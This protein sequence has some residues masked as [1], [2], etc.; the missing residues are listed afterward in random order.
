[1]PN[2]ASVIIS[3]YNKPHELEM[4]LCGLSL[5]NKA[6]S[7]ILVADDGSTQKT[8]TVIEKWQQIITSP[9]RHIWHEDIGNRKLKICNTAVKKA[10]GNYLLFLDGDSV[11]HSHWVSDHMDEAKNKTVL[12]GRRVR[13][14]PKISK[15]IDVSFVESKRLE[16][17]PGPILFSALRK[18]TKRYLLG[19]RLPRWLARCCHPSERRLMGVNFSLHKTLFESVGRYHDFDENIYAS[20]ER[21]REDAQLEIQL[22]KSGVHRFPLLNRAIVYHLYH[23]ERQPNK[24]I[25]DGIEK[26]YKDALRYRKMGKG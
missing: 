15:D 14:G 16:I 4:V 10:T 12:C 17:I 11:P 22:L 26:T 1:M 19:I 13:L 5:Q 9:V 18:D 23:P 2:S 7:E 21:R 6:P 20:K 8:A 25:N 3:T 24:N